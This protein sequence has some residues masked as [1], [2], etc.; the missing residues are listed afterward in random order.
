MKVAVFG[1]PGGGKSTLALQI[2][3]CTG[4]PLHQLDL[5]QFSEGGD[6]VPDDVFLHRHSEI[7]TGHRWVI[8]GFG[9]LQ[10]F[11]DLLAAADIL[12]YVERP[13]ITHYWWVTK[14]FLM[15]P[16]SKPLGWPDGSPLVKSTID[17][18]KFLRLSDRFWTPA[19]RERL[20]ALRP[21]KRVYLIGSQVDAQTMLSELR[22][23]TAAK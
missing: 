5:L 2:A 10:S 8:D 9:T 16:F 12:V 20:V 4:L 6:K 11:K 14:R 18:Y 17:S 1:K 22:S 3:R 7:L 15:S 19:F 23:R 13:A 21:A